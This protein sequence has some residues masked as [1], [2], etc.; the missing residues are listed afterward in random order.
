MSDPFVPECVDCGACCFG[1]D[2]WVKVSP[3]DFERMDDG[4][5]SLTELSKGAGQIDK[6]GKLHPDRRMRMDHRKCSALMFDKDT[7]RWGCSIYEV[8]PD[9]CRRFE[10]GSDRCAS[11][12]KTKGT[13]ALTAASSLVRK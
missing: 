11:E 8:R 1:H 4:A 5:R 13:M 3:S 2:Q 12:R 6:S 9:V 7:S 10:R